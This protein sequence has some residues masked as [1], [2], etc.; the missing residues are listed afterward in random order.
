MAAGSAATA[1]RYLDRARQFNPLSYSALYWLAWAQRQAGD[2]AGASETTERAVRIAPEDPN[3]GA[4]AGEMAL[5][6][7]HWEAAIAHF[8]RAVDRAPAAHLRFHAGLLDAAAAAGKTAEAAHAYARATSLFTDE[9]VVGS[10]ARCLAPADRYLLAR[11]SRVAARLAPNTAEVDKAAALA[12][13]ERLGQ[14][15]PRGICATGGRVGQTSP[16]SA[17]VSFWRAWSEGGRPAAERYLLPERRR[18]PPEQ[19]HAE[20]SELSRSPRIRVAWIYSLS[21][22]PS[23]ATVVYQVERQEDDGPKHRCA[24]TDTRFTSQGWLL[25]DLPILDS[26]PCR[27]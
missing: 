11:M 24:R 23:Q 6:V 1:V 20:F 3:T 10:E 14:P 19:T 16:E 5:A 2:L 22:G 25:A 17:V 12:R 13:A 18:N 4:L 7:G 15:D 21:G 8:Q 26:G 9:R 27:P